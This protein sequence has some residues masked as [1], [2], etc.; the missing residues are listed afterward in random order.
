MLSGRPA[1]LGRPSFG[2]AAYACD[3]FDIESEPRQL[4]VRSSVH[5]DNRKRTYYVIVTRRGDGAFPFSWEIQRRREAMGVKVSGS[6]Y[7]SYRA[8]HEA[9]SQALDK[10]LDDLSQEGRIS[11]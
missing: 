1:G 4:A 11:R 10:F 3:E 2:L 5:A 6:G 8:A 9:G 7:R